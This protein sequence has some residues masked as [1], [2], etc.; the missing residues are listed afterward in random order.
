MILSS[1]RMDDLEELCSEV[2]ILATGRVVFS[3]PLDKLAGENRELD[4]RL[5]TSDSDA[6]RAGRRG[7]RRDRV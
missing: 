5:M 3:G 2:T 7:N 4:Y 6:A 1:H